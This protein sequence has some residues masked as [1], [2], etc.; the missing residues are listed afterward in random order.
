MEVVKKHKEEAHGPVKVS[1]ITI[2]TSRYQKI[3]EGESVQDESGDKAIEMIKKAGHIVISKKIV[4]DDSEMIKNELL[5]S[6][7]EE[8]A[9]VVIM[10]GGTGLSPRDVTI[11]TVQ[12]LFDKVI[13]GFGEIFR[14]VSYQE[15]G[16]A[17]FLSR[18]TAG[19]ID[20]R[21]VFCLPGSPY[22][23]ITALNIILGELNHAVYIAKG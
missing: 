16:A 23:V 3:L 5:K 22:A 15:I 11:E 10:I 19:T 13:S 12:P 6:I 9:D 14:M 21:L 4:N 2:S 17:A 20:K 7:R 18:A 8:G 1:V